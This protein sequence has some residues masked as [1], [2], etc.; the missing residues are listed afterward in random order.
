MNQ[1]DQMNK[2]NPSAAW[3]VGVGAVVASEIALL[4][5]IVR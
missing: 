4:P 2:F 3:V 5:Q 1:I